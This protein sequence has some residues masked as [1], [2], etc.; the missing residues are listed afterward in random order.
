[1]SVKAVFVGMP[2]SGKTT[3]GRLVA[4]SLG[5]EFA[6]SDELIERTAGRT[7]PEI[8]A[9]SGERGF[10]KIEAEVIATALEDFDGVLSLGGGAILT[11]STLGVLLGHPV[12]LIDVR[13]EE[14]VRRLVHSSTVRPLVQHD[15][16]RQVAELHAARGSLYRQV[17]THTVAS[18][19]GPVVGVVRR[20]LDLMGHPEVVA[21][22]GK[23]KHT[24][25]AK[26]ETL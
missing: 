4:Q 2:G 15:P 11:E 10:R 22:T 21:A 16:V 9:D 18:D 6:D 14:L 5:V 13:E 3:V 1:M 19:S 20:V 8:F 7:V 24:S 25:H 23:K 12:F 26:G 17:A